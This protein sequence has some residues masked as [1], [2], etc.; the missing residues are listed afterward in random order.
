[1]T[2]SLADW[3]RDSTRMFDI[4]DTQ[5]DDIAKV[6]VRRISAR[7][8][9]N[10]PGYGNQDPEDTPYIPTGRLRG[11]WNYQFS[12]GGETSRIEGGPYSDYGAETLSRI[13]AQIEVGPIRAE[14]YLV[15]DVAYGYIVH[16]GLGYHVNA[17][18]WVEEAVNNAGE[19]LA[20]ARR[21]VMG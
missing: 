3:N 15:N 6:Y 17:R 4:F 10:T 8:V 16:W 18:R 7:V 20:D 1:M 2:D 19:D 11:G 21:E 5:M 14:S 9:Q 13:Y 12:P